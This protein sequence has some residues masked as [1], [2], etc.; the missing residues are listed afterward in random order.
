MA[1][2]N[3]EEPQLLDK[4]HYLFKK[5]LRYDPQNALQFCKS[6]QKK[7]G[8]E[9]SKKIELQSRMETFRK[10][11]CMHLVWMLDRFGDQLDTRKISEYDTYRLLS[12]KYDSVSD[13]NALD[14]S[15]DEHTAVEVQAAPVT[16]TH[17]DSDRGTEHQLTQH[18]NALRYL[19]QAAKDK[20]T[21]QFSE[22]LVKRVHRMLMKGIY[23]FDTRDKTMKVPI[24]AGEYRL[25]IVSA[26]FTFTYP[27]HACIPQGMK[28][29]V[30]GY[31]ER[32]SRPNH[33]PYSLA[34]WLLFELLQ[35]HP[36]E[37]GN[38][39]VSRLFWCYS[40][41]RD[42]LPFPVTPFPDHKK[43]YKKYIDCIERDRELSISNNLKHLTS[44]TVI[45]VTTIWKNFIF[46]LQT[47]APD[48][49]KEIIQW[50]NDSDNNLKPLET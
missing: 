38:G 31:N 15:S 13:D 40:L 34:A 42:G 2:I 23:N 50:L 11:R 44:L 36:F 28:R 25:G 5:V 21:V 30:D 6:L 10:Y 9:Y 39:R 20:V 3:D 18:M 29:I 14:D 41:M 33:D 48:E 16:L 32:S 12:D 8:A 4:H 46:N 43:A 27:D 49:Y 35:L 26:G 37:D 7:W 45:S 17:A 1:T 24:E 22:E 19:L 47:E